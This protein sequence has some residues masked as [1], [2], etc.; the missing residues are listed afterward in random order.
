MGAGMTAERKII[1]FEINEIP[2]RVIDHYASQHPRS[3]VARLMA[4]AKQFETICEDQVELDPWIS[5]PTLHRGVID[6]QHRI[7]HL[8]Q[9][10]D[11]ANRSYPPVWEL[12]ARSGRKVGIMGSIHSSTVPEDLSQYAFYVPDFFA[13]DAFAHPPELTAFQKFNLAMTRQSARNVD[14]R[15]PIR[16]TR[17]FVAHYAGHGMSIGTVG[18][19]MAELAR[20]VRK[21]HLRCRRRAIQPLITLDLFLNQMR[22]TRPDFGT[23]HTNHVAAAMHRYWAATFPDDTEN[24]MPAEWLAKYGDEIDYSMGALDRMLG[25][26]VKFCKRDDAY[27]L[28]C[29]S[30]MGQAA[31]K[32]RVSKMF[33]TVTDLKRFM[34]RFGCGP[35]EWSQRFAMVPC[36]SV[37]VDPAKADAFERRL[38]ELR[39]GDKRMIKGEREVS[40]MSYD[41]KENSFQL[42]VYFDGD[43]A[44]RTCR[45]GDE[46]LRFED[47]G[48]G[49]HSHEDD[50]ACSARHTPQG[51]LIVYDPRHPAVDRNRSQ[52]STLAVAPA[53]LHA[54]GIPPP[55]YMNEPDPRILD[56]TTA[57]ASVSVSVTGGGVELPVIRLKPF[58]ATTGALAA[59]EGISIQS[60]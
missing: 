21:P 58:H 23:V 49:N 20:E 45:L 3:H 41:R 54:F 60:A 17:D 26:L 43:N 30:S 59:D 1:L 52:I 51:V 11:F 50:V 19:A 44:G 34:T 55:M 8:G 27:M 40:P 13:H 9:S 4:T 39:V 53:I 24:A 16:E 18:T 5:W 7:F 10:L 2:Y 47:L 37:L 22:R 12:L 29:A 42:F 35:G 31:I 14:R 6:E 48:F 57:G 36:I 38:Q 46:V 15:L 25:R 32:T 33:A 56:T 28:V